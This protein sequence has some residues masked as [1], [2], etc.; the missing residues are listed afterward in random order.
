MSRENKTE[1]CE[2]CRYWHKMTTL[3]AGVSDPLELEQG[4][5]RRGLPDPDRRWPPRG[6]NWPYTM[7][8]DWCGQF[9][10]LFEGILKRA[11]SQGGKQRA[12]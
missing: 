6:V 9:Q 2:N 1:V 10:S 3:R 4:Q 12:K 5:C 11:E 8:N 7:A